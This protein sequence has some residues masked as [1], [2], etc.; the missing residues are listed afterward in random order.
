MKERF[1]GYN[2]ENIFFIPSLQQ[3]SGYINRIN[4]KCKK[5]LI[6]LTE[7][8]AYYAWYNEKIK[9]F[10]TDTQILKSENKMD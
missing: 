2:V 5:L 4:V 1:L 7:T 8:K 9:F 6:F 10:M 3:V